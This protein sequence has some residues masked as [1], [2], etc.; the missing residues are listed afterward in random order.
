MSEVA[1]ASSGKSHQDENFPVAALLGR[2][3][4]APVLAFYNFVR[5]ADDVAD[6]ATLAPERKLALL[7][8]LARALTG[9]GPSD[10]VAEPLKQALSRT[11]VTDRHALDL[12]EAFKLD[13]TKNRYRDFDDLV[14]YCRLSAMPVGRYVL[15]LHGESRDTWVASDKLCAALQIINHL[16]DCGKDFRDLDRVYIPADALDAH[17]ARIDMLGAGRAAPELRATI[18]DL[19]RRTEKLLAES[20]VFP[21]QVRD[22]RLAMNVAAIQKLAERLTAG[23]L[24]RDPLYEKV[25]ASRAGFVTTAVAAAGVVLVRRALS[26]GG[27]RREGRT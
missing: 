11:R 6:H 25:H 27:N 20:A 5:A 23:L 2:R 4:R 22:L 17:G 26:L 24:V 9:Q 1:A 16:Q 7:D 13:V 19:A 3:Y 18:V 10:P 15:D 12:I 14:D 21:T 8:G